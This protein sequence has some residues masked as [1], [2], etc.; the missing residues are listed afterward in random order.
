MS[1]FFRNYDPERYVLTINGQPVQGLVTASSIKVSRVTK[2]FTDVV[3]LQGDV[4]DVRSQDKRGRI[5]FRTMQQAPINDILSSFI[6]AD[7]TNGSGTFEAQL[8]DLNGTTLHHG[9]NARLEGY[10]D[11]ARAATAGEFEWTVLVPQLEMFDGG[12]TS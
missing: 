3:G 4:V 9:D 6:L 12:A 8:E 2:L 1:G 11:D 10:P 7:E 5:V